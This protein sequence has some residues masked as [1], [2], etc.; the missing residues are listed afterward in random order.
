MAN[1]KKEKKPQKR[2]PIKK[3]KKE[4]VKVIKKEEVVTEKKKT[5]KH[6]YTSKEGIIIMILSIIIGALFGSAIT[7][8]LCDKKHPSELEEYDKV[9]NE[10]Y[11]NKYSNTNKTDMITSSITGLLSSLKD[12]YAY[13]NESINAMLLY[14]QETKGEF[15]GLGVNVLIDE[16]EKIKILNVFDGSPAAKA[17]I[18]ANDIIVRLNGNYYDANNYESFSYLVLSSNKG[19]KVEVELLRD[20]ETITKEVVLDKVEINSVSYYSKDSDGLKVGVFKISNFADN[21]YDQFYS[22][23]EE[24][25]DDGIEAI[26]I[27]LRDNGEGLMKNAKKIASLFLEKGSVVYQTFY[28]GEYKEVLNNENGKIKLPVAVIVNGNTMSTGEMLASTL[29]ENLNAP[30]IGTRTFGKGLLQEVIPLYDGYA[31]IYSTEEWVTSKKNKVEEVGIAPTVDL[32]SESTDTDMSV[33]KAIESIKAM[34]N[35]G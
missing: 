21:T 14:D 22:K 23:Y 34:I 24:A 12:R 35:I 13:V 26:V 1:E 27:D 4:E 9:Y 15:I 16:N 7:R 20:N 5:K 18:E 30:V 10:I 19:D 31:V 6:A 25:L 11:N 8:F 28:N 3:V 2:K 33:D 29:K 32:S 17:G